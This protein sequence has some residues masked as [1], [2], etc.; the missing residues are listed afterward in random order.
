MRRWWWR[1]CLRPWWRRICAVIL[2]SA[3]SI[4]WLTAVEV[5]IACWA[6]AAALSAVVCA[7]WAAA[8]AACA[9]LFADAAALLAASAVA[10]ACCAAALAA[11]AAL[12]AWSALAWARCTESTLAQPLS[13]S[14]PIM[15]VARVFLV[16]NL[17]IG[18]AFIGGPKGRDETRI[19]LNARRSQPVATFE[20][21]APPPG[22]SASA[23]LCLTG[24]G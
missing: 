14:P 22:C 9:A 23:T 24:P 13:M 2:A 1:Q 16:A 20:R 17:V 5:A 11:W 18:L 4:R 21:R 8:A 12:F 10:W 19:Y 15:R 3:A 6:V 7:L